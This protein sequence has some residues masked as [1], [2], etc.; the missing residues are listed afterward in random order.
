VVYVSDI[1]VDDQ[2]WHRLRLGFFAT[3]A[4]ANA[5]FDALRPRYPDGWVVRVPAAER[6]AARAN[7]TVTA[8]DTA[9]PTAADRSGVVTLTAGQAA[10]LLEQARGAI[11]DQ[12]YGQA[13]QIS[14]RVL[15][16]RPP[17]ET[18]EAR[19]LLGLARERNGQVASA[20]AEYRRYIADFP[21]GEASDRVWQRL[22]ALTTAREQPRDSIRQ[23]A[24][25]SRDSAWDIYGGISQYYGL[26]SVNFGGESG[27]VDQ[28]AIFT[29][30]DLVVRHTGD[31]FDVGSR[32]TL[33]YNYDLSSGEFDPG[34]QTWVYNLYVDLND[35]SHGLSSRLGRQTLRNQGVLGRFDGALVS[36]QWAPSYRLNLLAG[37]PVY[38]ADET[39]DTSRTFY[40]FSVD[41]LNLLD[42]F[43][44]NLFYNIQ[45]VDGVNDREAVGTEIRY[46]GDNR[47]FIASLDYDIGYG[48]LNN[49]V[50]LGNWTFD[51]RITV[52]GRYDLR[53]N[54]YLTTETALVGQPASSIQGLL[55]TYTEA[56]I[57][58]LALDRSGAMQSVAL[59]VA[60]PLSER[61]QISADVTASQYDATPASGG[62]PETPDSGTLIYSYLSLIGS[63]LVREGDVSILGLR[64][65]DGGTSKS[66]GIFLD[67]R[68]PLTNS[69]RLNPKVLLANREITSGDLTELVVRPGLGVLYRPGRHF[70]FD[71]EGGGEFGRSEG[72]GESN[73]STGYYVYMGYS[74]DF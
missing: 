63:S 30:A 65:A 17:A 25:A 60:R 26:D 15:E 29:D 16:G 24:T 57:R 46:F 23:G 20:I 6:L 67:S 5:A 52:N 35:R 41:V 64:Y 62:V 69:L 49:V 68:F 44:V 39:V 54:P 61:F 73:N 55:L 19:E 14:T 59:G 27:K 74:A 58:Q 51:N 33:A 22:A 9:E 42:M 7:M 70:Q 71:F 13:I 36:W 28:S 3:E 4:D 48:E 66:T 72:D 10:E 8:D 45:D 31:R 21:E 38:Y 50:A 11:I 47:S 1:Q 2:M 18:A 34:N 40:G 32:A 53:N 43:D 12:D 37:Y 56:E